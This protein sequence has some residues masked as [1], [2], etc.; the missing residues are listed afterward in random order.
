MYMQAKFCLCTAPCP[1][2]LTRSCIL[3]L[4]GI[5]IEYRKYVLWLACDITARCISNAAHPSTLAVPMPARCGV[6]IRVVTVARCHYDSVLF[7]SQGTAQHSTAQHSTA[8]H[9]LAW[10]GMAQHSIHK[11]NTAQLSCMAPEAFTAVCVVKI[12][13][14]AEQVLEVHCYGNP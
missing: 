6:D 8:R 10:H 4:A 13:R 12:I 11:H 14:Q 9:S 2:Y 5:I 1:A 7:I 3:R